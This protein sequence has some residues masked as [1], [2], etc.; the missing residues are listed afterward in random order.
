MDPRRRSVSDVMQEDV[1]A[2]GPDDRLDLADD[3]M[4]LGRVRHMPVVEGDTLVGL[5]TSRDLLAASLSRVLDFD[6]QHRRSFMRSVEVKEAMARN[7]VTLEPDATLREAA[8]LMRRHQIGC[9]PVVKSDGTLLG[10]VT[11]TDLLHAAYLAEEESPAEGLETRA[12]RQ[13]G[14]RLGA[15]LASLQRLR[16]ELRV[17]MHLAKAEGRELF[18]TAERRWREV[19]NKLRKLE[20][21]AEAPLREVKGAAERLVEEIRDA[22]QRIKASL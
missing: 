9:V 2:L 13:L 17:Q 21:E 22:Y 8:A 18:E 5:V 3:I 16:D 4:R 10:L 19:E 20:R 12:E 14:E 1:V 15:E 6:S 7:L 11:E